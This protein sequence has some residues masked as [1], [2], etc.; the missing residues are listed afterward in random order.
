MPTAVKAPEL[1]KK[2]SSSSIPSEHEAKQSIKILQARAKLA[3]DSQARKLAD[4]TLQKLG[5]FLLFEAKKGD[6]NKQKQADE[7]KPLVMKLFEKAHEL[8]ARL[9]L[10]T[11]SFVVRVAKQSKPKFYHNASSAGKKAVWTFKYEDVGLPSVN[12]TFDITMDRSYASLKGDEN[13]QAKKIGDEAVA[14][15]KK[16]TKSKD[17]KL[18]K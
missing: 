16:I 18:V 17:V 4:L 2:W 1:P 3:G 13:K 5:N 15:T 8:S 12:G 10:P 14:E 11:G 6:Q 7:I 9:K